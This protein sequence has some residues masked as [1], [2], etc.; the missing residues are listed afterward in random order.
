MKAI[1]LAAGKGTRLRPLTDTTPKPLVKVLGKEI[2]IYTLELLKPYVEEFIIVI[3]YKK[4]LFQETLGDSFGG[5]KIT[6]HTQGEEPGTGGAI[7]GIDT[8]G[9]GDYIIT[10]G[11]QIFFKNDI[12]PILLGHS[13]GVLSTRVTNP[14]N[15]GIFQIST[16]NYLKSIIEKPTQDVGNLANISFYKVPSEIF[17]VI[18]HVPLSPRGEIEITD[19]ITLLTNTYQFKVHE[20]QFI[21]I[22]YT[23]NLLDAN[24]SFLGDLSESTIEGTVEDNVIIKGNIILEAGAVIKSGTY[25][26]GNCYFGKNSI[27]GPNAYVRGNTSLGDGGKIGFSVEVKNSYIGENSKLSHLSYLG[28]SIVGN[29]VNL[30]CGFKTANLRHDGKNMRVMVKGNLIDTGRRKLGGII[31]DDVKTGINTSIY[32][33][34]IIETGSSTLPGE[35]VK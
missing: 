22:G 34:R 24:K 8:K 20:G 23:W 16:N 18:N 15:Y 27:V 32:P 11:D 31:G 29:N 35:I 33:G 25:I 14:E 6:Y 1:I 4:E 13:Y 9:S 30:G 3:Q 5:I 7:K 10:V 28:D 21:D 19:A 12:K 26:E 2:I 17:E